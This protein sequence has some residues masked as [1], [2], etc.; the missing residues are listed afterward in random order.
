MNSRR[1]MESAHRD[2]A[3]IISRTFPGSSLSFQAAEDHH[4]R[5]D[6][7]GYP[8]GKRT[9]RFHFV[10]LWRMRCLRRPVY[11]PALPIQPGTRTALTTSPACRQG[12]RQVQAEKLLHLSFYPV[13]SIVELSDG[14]V[15]CVRHAGVSN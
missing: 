11:A 14:A 10:K 1:H 12:S 6:G 13:G 9:C 3:Q 8:G 15:P 5:L 2:R 7:T 4:E